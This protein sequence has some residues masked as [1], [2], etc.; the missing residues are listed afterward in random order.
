[1]STRPT[2]RCAHPHS[3]RESWSSARTSA[4]SIRTVPGNV[5]C[6]RPVADQC[7]GQGGGGTGRTA[8]QLVGTGDRSDR[9]R[10]C[11]FPQGRM[12]DHRINLTLY[13]LDEI[14]EGNL[15]A[16]VGPCARSTRQTSWRPWPAADGHGPGTAAL[17][18]R[19]AG[20]QRATRRRDPARPLPGPFPQLVIY[21][22]ER[23]G[24]GSPGRTIPASSGRSPA[25]AN[26]SPTWCDSANS[27]R[28]R[29]WSITTP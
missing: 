18:R 2:P 6:C 4:R 19:P 28:C 22:A 13:K 21:L 8:S 20:R 14:L 12:T 15:D 1:M 5:P 27:G 3:Q 23:E 24:G 7:P 25:T 26:R 9:I 17:R 16:V 11:N 10:T 29:R